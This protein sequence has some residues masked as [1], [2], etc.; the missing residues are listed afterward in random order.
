MSTQSVTKTNDENMRDAI[1]EVRAFTKSMQEEKAKAEAKAKGE[2]WTKYAALSMALVALIAGYAMAKGGTCSGR[3]SKDL[4]EATYNQTQASDQWSFFQAKAQKEML[5]ETELHLR[6]AVQDKD[7]ARRAALESIVKRYEQEKGE[8]KV[9]AEEYEAAR[10]KYRKDSEEQTV[11]GGKFG[12]AAQTFQI[13]LAIGG[14]CLLAKKRWLWFIT[15][16]VAALAV[17]RLAIALA[18]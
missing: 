1:L 4:S 16:A 13:A 9:K 6:D 11:L 5:L 18:G 10:N 7:Q 15:L 3:V 17:V 12:L 8:I 2:S 14:L